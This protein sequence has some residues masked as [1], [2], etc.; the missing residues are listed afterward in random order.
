MS[1]TS[2]KR[3]WTP[4]EFCAEY[5]FSYRTWKRLR[6]AGDAPRLTWISANKCIIR[7]EHAKAWLDARTEPASEEAAA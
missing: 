5:G 6:A 2:P 1:T 4:R 7:F 3:Y